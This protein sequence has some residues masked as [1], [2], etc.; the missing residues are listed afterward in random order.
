AKGQVISVTPITEPLGAGGEVRL[1]V[2]KGPNVVIMPA[3][4]GETISAAKAALES[5]GL[6]VLVDTNQLQ[7]KWGIAKVKRAS[8]AAGTSLRSGDS[9]TISSK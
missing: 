6:S 5:L 7:S 8:V 2:S 3:V 9:V 1:L 4:V